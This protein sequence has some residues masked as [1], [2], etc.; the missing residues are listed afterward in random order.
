VHIPMR[1]HNSSMNVANA[2]AIAAYE[3]GRRIA[4][5]QGGSAAGATRRSSASWSSAGLPRRRH[6][7][8][9]LRPTRPTC[10]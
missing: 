3:I 2:C 4:S 9:R 10:P 1:G 7:G 8:S 5:S 6:G